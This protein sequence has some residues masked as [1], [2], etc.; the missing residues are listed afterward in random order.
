VFRTS[1]DFTPSFSSLLDH[2][3]ASLT[4]FKFL[5]T[6]KLLSKMSDCLICLDTCAAGQEIACAF[7]AHSFC[8]G[9]VEQYLLNSGL[10][11]RCAHTECAQPWSD[12]FIDSAVGDKFRH[13]A[14]RQH[15]EK[16]LV[17]VE[18]ARLA[19]F[20][21]DARRYAIA[22]A[23][24][25][26]MT[27]AHTTEMAKIADF[28]ARE[29]V[30]KDAVHEANTRFWTHYS[31]KDTAIRAET[32]KERDRCSDA[33]DHFYAANE[34][35]YKEVMKIHNA[36][37]AAN[38][39][40]HIRNVLSYYGAPVR[41]ISA[42]HIAAGDVLFGEGWRAPTFGGAGGAAA[43]PERV[44]ILRGCPAE[45][46]RGFLSVGGI[47]GICDMK[48]C[49]CCHEIVGKKGEAV[50]QMGELE[51]RIGER[52][53]CCDPAS[54]E[55]AKLL[56]KETRPCPKCKALIFKTDGCDQ[57]WCTQCQTPF[58]WRT[59]K[60]EEGRVHNPHYYEWLRRTQ[61]PDGVP[62]EAP[63]PGDVGYPQEAAD[64]CRPE[65]DL[66]DERYRIEDRMTAD[67]A[68][69]KEAPV[70]LFISVIHNIV[71]HLMHGGYRFR[72]NDE[73]HRQRIHN[74]NVTYLSGRIDEK[75][76]RRRVF[77]EKRA[78]Q[79]HATYV[80]ILRTLMATCRDVLN[81]FFLGRGSVKSVDTVKQLITLYGFALEAIDK[82]KKR[83]NYNGVNNE[84]QF[85]PAQA[86]LTYTMPEDDPIHTIFPGGGRVTISQMEAFQVWICEP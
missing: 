11:I 41:Y 9:C 53:H 46:C 81:S 38:R 51:F 80:D 56:Q 32:T 8:R 33:L 74:I 42:K 83:F 79:R 27:T 75:E 66:V 39:G 84:D 5:T 22:F 50:E 65:T 68:V 10:Q 4:T 29:K 37:N 3:Q 54:V 43:A 49:L 86:S 82:Y 77:I 31:S 16:L 55:T 73:D 1:R 12:D 17:D 21:E 85:M 15:R 45:A 35:E 62:R 44:Q 2:V 63:Q 28:K 48:I 13:G 58:S 71:S 6:F 30:F 25:E 70:R 34:E 23:E 61:G 69:M 67:V 76:W 72:V 59:G 20:Q 36:A 78:Q 40:P 52:V 7:C 57:M 19:E 14:L 60:V 64:C 24:N 26:R 47:C 18:K